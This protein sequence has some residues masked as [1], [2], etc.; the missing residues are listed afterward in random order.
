M[1]SILEVDVNVILEHGVTAAVV[2][3]LVER[4]KEKMSTT[5]VANAIGVTY[6]T[7]QKNLRLL[8]DA[9]LIQTNGSMFYPQ[10][11]A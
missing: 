10:T 6:P 2:L 1:R 9:G 8:A 11:N 7:A 3:A 5:E 4:N